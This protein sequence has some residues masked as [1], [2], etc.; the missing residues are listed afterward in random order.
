MS[1]DGV[2]TTNGLAVIDQEF[3]GD[4]A[5][6]PPRAPRREGALQARDGKRKNEA[7]ERE[8]D[9]KERRQLDH[10]LSI[11]KGKF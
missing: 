5:A 11:E 3:L 4:L 6:R 2:R 10:L 1:R 8:K 9:E 7:K